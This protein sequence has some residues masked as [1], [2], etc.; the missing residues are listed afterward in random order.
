MS[1]ISP[2]SF[3]HDLCVGAGR[4]CR[5]VVAYLAPGW[6][7]PGPTTEQLEAMTRQEVCHLVDAADRIGDGPLVNALCQYARQRFGPGLMW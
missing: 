6:Y 7:I 3:R 1:N 5:P 4:Y 2:D